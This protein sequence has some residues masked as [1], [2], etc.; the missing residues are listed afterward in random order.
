MT[1]AFL[2][3]GQW[4]QSEGLNDKMLATWAIAVD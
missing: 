3:R 1:G 4:A 2:F